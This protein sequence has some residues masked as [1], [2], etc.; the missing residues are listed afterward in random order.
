M[1][2][3]RQSPNAG[4]IRRVMGAALFAGLL[5]A[6]FCISLRPVMYVWRG[7]IDFTE[8]YNHLDIEG[9]PLFAGAQAHE[10]MLLIRDRAW[11][12]FRELHPEIQPDDIVLGLTSH[13]H[14]LVSEITIGGTRREYPPE[15]FDVAAMA[16]LDVLQESRLKLARLEQAE[17]AMEERKGNK[18]TAGHVNTLREKLADLHNSE[19]FIKVI[20]GE[21]APSPRIPGLEKTLLAGAGLGLAAGLLVLVFTAWAKD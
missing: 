11:A 12:D 2:T 8:Y 21:T 20:P 15:Y 9:L 18:L 4:R 19:H 3:L 13:N 6:S 16:T 17:L 1:N 7:R 5:A 10:E 14:G